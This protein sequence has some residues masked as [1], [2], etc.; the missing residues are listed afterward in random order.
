[1]GILE[2]PKPLAHTPRLTNLSRFFQEP[3]GLR[4]VLEVARVVPAYNLI[5]IVGFATVAVIEMTIVAPHYPVAD[6]VWY[7]VD[8]RHTTVGVELELHGLPFHTTKGTDNSIRPQTY[9]R[10]SLLVVQ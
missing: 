8:Q 9:R 4:L 7:A 1:M 2:C 5:L 3:A 10:E 6:V